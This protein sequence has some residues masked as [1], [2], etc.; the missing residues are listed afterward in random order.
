LGSGSYGRVYLGQTKNGKKKVAIKIVDIGEVKSEKEQEY[1]IEEPKFLRKIQ[2][3]K[4]PNI[5]ELITW[6]KDRMG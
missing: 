1:C 4:H 3:L 6:Y 5:M 2:K